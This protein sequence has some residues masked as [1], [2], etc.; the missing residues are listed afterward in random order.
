MPHTVTVK[1]LEFLT[2][3]VL[4][5]VTDKPENYSFVPGQ[6]TELALDR[7][8]YREQKRPFTFTSLPED[9]EL[10]FTIKVYPSHD[11][12]TEQLLSLEIGDTLLIGDAWGAIQYKGAGAFIA[13]G[14]G[15]TPFLSILKDLRRDQKLEGHQLFFANHTQKDI[16]LK[17]TLRAWLGDDFHNILSDQD[18]DKYPHGYIDK[19]FL[20]NHDLDVSKKVYLCGPPQMMDAVQADLFEMGLSKKQL[21]TEAFE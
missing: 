16:I 12:V 4:R 18:H 7:D 15:I 8:G 21:V 17:E 1:Q 9:T 2:H 19:D 6:A 10:E 5:I 13:G 11:G 14:A 3:N 20:E